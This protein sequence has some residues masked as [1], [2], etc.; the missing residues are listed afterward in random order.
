MPAA[1]ARLLRTWHDDAHQRITASLPL[2]QSFLG[3]DLVVAKDDYP[4][5]D[6]AFYQFVR[7]EVRPDDKVLDMGCGSGI[8]ALLAAQSSS[9]V[10]AVDIN[11]AAVECARANAHRNSLQSRITC[12]RSDVFSAVRESFD[13]VIFNPP[14]RWFAPRSPLEMATADEGYLALRTFMAQARSHLL[15][16]G[17]I[18]LSFG[19]SGDIDYLHSLID[20]RGFAKEVVPSGTLKRHGL[21]V[22]YYHFRLTA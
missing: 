12:H 1:R 9:H 11:P 16:Q 13:L 17:R 15:P 19:S 21:T 7:A 5:G 10:V 8:V 18:L 22:N 2:R 4:P 20:Q 3:L 14:Y 6:E